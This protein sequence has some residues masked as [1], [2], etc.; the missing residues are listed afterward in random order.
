MDALQNVKKKYQ[1]QRVIGQGSFGIVRK[2]QDRKSGQVLACKTIAKSKVPNLE[3]L[4]REVHNLS[5]V[6]HP[7]IIEFR[8][9]FEDKHNIHLITELCQGGELYEQVL[10]SGS[11]EE[12]TAVKII[13]NILD[14]ISYCHEVYHIVHRDLKASNFLF[15][16]PEDPTH[17]K[18]IDFGL[19]KY[20]PRRN[21]CGE[22]NCKNCANSK[23]NNHRE[24]DP[25]QLA[26]AQTKETCPEHSNEEEDSEEEEIR[27]SPS[28]CGGLGIMNSRVGTPYYVAPEILTQEFYTNKC[29]VWSIGVIS[30]LVLTASLPF[31]GKD[32]RETIQL[33]IEDK[34]AEFPP[35]LWNNLSPQ[36]LDFCR[37]LLQRDPQQRPT[38]RQAMSH[39]W[40]VQYCGQPQALPPPVPLA[41]FPSKKKKN[42]PIRSMSPIRSSKQVGFDETTI[43]KQ[44][45]GILPRIFR[46]SK[47]SLV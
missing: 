29:D 40:I 14:A 5:G 9:V 44:R 36:A 12:T 43:A 18:I 13:R 11:F 37:Q 28:G 33:L 17:I 16:S 45:K 20:L 15:F 27:V 25:Q 7:Y 30:Y 8:D 31:L 2:C 22:N 24:E 21:T 46:K 3:L 26:T 6:R 1:L 23:E 10:A 32:E 4:E 39:P 19:S 41:T 38:A 47:S 35:Q 42:K 34:H